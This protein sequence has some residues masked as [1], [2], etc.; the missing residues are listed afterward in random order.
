MSHDNTCVL[1]SVPSLNCILR[2]VSEIC[3][4]NFPL[5]LSWKY[6]F[7]SVVEENGFKFQISSL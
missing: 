6:Q 2:T 3:N 1:N 4:Y 7:S 5:P